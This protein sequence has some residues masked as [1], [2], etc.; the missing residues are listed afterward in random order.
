[1]VS[2][3]GHNALIGNNDLTDAWRK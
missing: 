2:I 1:M 3:T